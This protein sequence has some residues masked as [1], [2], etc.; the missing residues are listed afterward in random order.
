[1]PYLKGQDPVLIIELAGL[2]AVATL[3][4]S[5]LPALRA[6]RVNPLEAL[7]AE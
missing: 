6:T 4:A 2:L 5:W 3:L 1:M 7:R